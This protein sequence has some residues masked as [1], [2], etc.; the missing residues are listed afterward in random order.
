MPAYAE[1]SEKEILNEL[2]SKEED[3]PVEIESEPKI[4]EEVKPLIERL[5]EEISLTKPITDDAGQPLLSSSAPQNP[6][7]I[8]PIT[9]S[10]YAIGLSKKVN[11]SL[12]WLTEW[13][14]RLIKIFGDKIAFRE[15][16]ENE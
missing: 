9:K 8:L 7:I 10:V 2:L 12:R 5:E 1:Q 4:K 15:V 14:R 11:E 13:C 3:F 6:I 16:R